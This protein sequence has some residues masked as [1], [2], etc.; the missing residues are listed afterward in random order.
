MADKERKNLCL[1]CRNFDRNTPNHNEVLTEPDK[2]NWK[3][4]ACRLYPTVTF[5]HGN[6]WCR[7][8]EPA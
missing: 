6:E 1:N 2:R 8:H 3:E 4:F 5:K 7:Q